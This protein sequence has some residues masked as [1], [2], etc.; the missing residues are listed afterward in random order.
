MQ[1]SDPGERQ[2]DGQPRR[3]WPVPVSDSLPLS[4]SPSAWRGSAQAATVGI[5]IILFLAALFQAR[6]ILVPVAAAFV[7]AMMLAPL[8]QHARRL[9]VPSFVTAT[10][11]WLMAVAVF[12]GLIT[13]LSA[14]VVEWIGKAPD[15]G[16][17]F[18]DKFA[19]LERPLSALRDLRN[20]IL[21]SQSGEGVKVD[22]MGIAKETVSL[23][24]PA[25]GQVVIF[26]ATLFFMLLGREALRH[27]VVG[28]FHSREARLRCLKIM[29][30]VEHNLTGYLSV[31]A[32]INFAVGL[33]AGAVAW[34]VGLPNPL[35]WAVLGFVLNFIPYVGA[36]TLEIGMFMV[37]MVSFPT[38]AHAAIA[39]L[40]YLGLA[41]LEGQF[42]TPSILGRH[43]TI[44][45]L[46]VFLSL[47]FWTWLWG[48]LG[49]FL[50][51]PILIIGQVA[52]A[53]L[54]PKHEPDLPD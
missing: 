39:P 50:S 16:R 51:M 30:D 25:I 11:L 24:T 19:L 38:L 5:F 28:F 12:Y 15:I 45:P 53:H 7:V 10:V 49:T 35:A 20:A 17:S 14:P 21:P 48:P 26:F 3:R 32:V 29:N 37:G 47:V 41:M 52:L 36:L 43:F 27:V 9:G 23:V 31:V 8:S 44:N 33:C 54:F 40:A 34:A 42:I 22:V 1:G 2:T 13:L 4:A 6:A 18:Q 46:T